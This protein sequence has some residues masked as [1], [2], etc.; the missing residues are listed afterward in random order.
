MDDSVT[1]KKNNAQNSFDEYEDKSLKLDFDCMSDAQELDASAQ[2]EQ[3]FWK[4]M[5]P[6]SSPLSF[7]KSISEIIQLDQS[8]ICSKA[9][10]TEICAKE[11]S[12]SEKT[13]NVPSQ[14]ALLEMERLINQ[15]MLAFKQEL[16]QELK[17]K[18]ETKVS[19]G[20]NDVRAV[21]G[22]T[23]WSAGGD[24]SSS[25][26]D[27]GSYIEE[28]EIRELAEYRNF[29]EKTPIL[30][31]SLAVKTKRALCENKAQDLSDNVDGSMEHCNDF[32]KTRD[33]LEAGNESSKKTAQDLD[34]TLKKQ[35]TEKQSEGHQIESL[36]MNRSLVEGLPVDKDSHLKE[37]KPPEE[38][39]SH[40]NT[41]RVELEPA[42]PKTAL[43]VLTALLLLGSAVFAL[44]FFGV[45]LELKLAQDNSN[46]MA[47]NN[48][49]SQREIED[50]RNSLDAEIK[51][52]RKTESELKLAQG[53]LDAL[54][55]AEKALTSELKLA[56]INLDELRRDKASPQREIENLQN[57]LD[58]ETK[59][60]RKT[61]LYSSLIVA[62]LVVG[63]VG[64]AILASTKNR[65]LAEQGKLEQL[66][67][68]LDVAPLSLGIESDEG[69]MNFFIKRNAKIPT[70]I[71]KT[72][73]TA[74]DNQQFVSFPVYEGEGAMTKDNNLLGKFE[75]S[76][77]PAPRGVS[78][79]E[80][81]FDI[82]ANG[83]LNVSAQDKSTGKQSK[84][85]IT[86][87]KGRLWKDEIE[88]M[89]KEAQRLDN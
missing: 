80:V 89:I 30:R 70:K 84:I 60:H 40:L 72:F 28:P 47:H 21:S 82:D 66:R 83:I 19:N 37:T 61:W 4:S 88:R 53:T 39:L 16:R 79:I 75:L 45:G 1:G 50:L 27:M 62:I 43:F 10:N 76:I 44:G 33:K 22:S 59:E 3:A 74:S 15:K 31:G 13:A 57:S 81:T 56:Q 9:S 48:A 7:E 42:F 26:T 12:I 86:N 65:F 41:A 78:Q 85:T 73:T 24:E 35:E 34:V 20:M 25:K 29:I 36:Q 54:Q 8:S 32:A 49:S 11:V 46:G 63:L 58:A 64:L 55:K 68:L 87:T 5:F 51:Q 67:L 77:P 17:S 69:V 71:S 2:F 6:T 52:R 38:Q 23:Y 14:S 18:L